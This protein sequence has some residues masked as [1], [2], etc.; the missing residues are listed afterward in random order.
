MGSAGQVGP[1]LVRGGDRDGVDA[2]D[3]DTATWHPKPFPLDTASFLVVRSSSSLSLSH[4]FVSSFKIESVR[5]G[6]T[7]PGESNG[8]LHV[9]DSE[10]SMVGSLDESHRLEGSDGSSNRSPRNCSNRSW[11]LRRTA[12]TLGVSADPDKGEISS[13]TPFS[14][15]KSRARCPRAG[16][17]CAGG[18]LAHASVSSAALA[19]E[20][21]SK[22][23]RTGKAA[24]APAT[25][26]PAAHAEAQAEELSPPS[27][28]AVRALST[29]VHRLARLGRLRA[30]KSPRRPGD[31]S[32]ATPLRSMARHSQG[33]ALV[34]RARRGK[35]KACSCQRRHVE[36]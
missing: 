19:A 13:R 14:L 18:E 9:S 27:A 4:T 7:E 29:G 6:K 5:S 24:P 35:R 16:A 26:L 32:P 12:S 2:V 23:A 3:A 15:N 22:G 28:V 8:P 31:V 34:R 33:R 17:R 30:C 10:P 20:E 1:L 36:S 11:L 25:S 21:L